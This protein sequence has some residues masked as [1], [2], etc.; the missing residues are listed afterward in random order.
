MISSISGTNSYYY[1]SSLQQADAQSLSVDDLFSKVDASGDGTVNKDEF[2]TFRANM[3]AQFAN[4][5]MGSK[6]DRG[7]GAATATD[8]LFSKIDTDGGG[9]VSVDEFNAFRANMQAHGN[10][11]MAGPPGP[12]PDLST[13][14]LFSKI[15]T[16]GDGSVSE[17]EFN[18]FR[19]NM[20]AQGSPPPPPSSDSTSS[21]TSSIFSAA[22]TNKDGT[23][24]TDEL[25]AFE[26]KIEADL[27]ALLQDLGMTGSSTSRSTGTTSTS[28]SDREMGATLFSSLIMEAI[29]KYMTLAGSNQ[30]TASSGLL[31]VA[32]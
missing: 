13:D 21:A 20:Q 17:E 11:E 23:V 4:S 30:S 12:P 5:V 10:K 14:D 7:T 15:D 25:T 2:N 24:S 8:D 32:G 18:T 28:S 29:G 9:S 31:N 19:S 27:A 16:D 6:F 1:L 26:S 22:D 3:E